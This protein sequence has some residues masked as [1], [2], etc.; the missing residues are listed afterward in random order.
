MFLVSVTSEPLYAALH[1]HV[2]FRQGSQI[3]ACGPPRVRVVDHTRHVLLLTLIS[4]IK[5]AHQQVAALRI[6]RSHR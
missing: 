5:A 2:I 6:K 4:L 1:L 3:L